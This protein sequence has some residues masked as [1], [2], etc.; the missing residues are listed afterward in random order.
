[1][2]DANHAHTKVILP[3]G[4]RNTKARSEIFGLF[5]HATSPLAIKDITKVVSANEASVY[6]TIRMLE[7]DG[8]VSSIR[9]PDGTVRYELSE[10]HHHIICVDCGL[11]E[12]MPCEPTGAIPRGKSSQFSQ[13]L[14]HEVTYYGRCVE[15]AR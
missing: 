8:L 7:S 9:Y 14:G 5:E 15:C 4:R 2:K 10:H 13:M 3:T 1:M 12:H 6:R 11:T